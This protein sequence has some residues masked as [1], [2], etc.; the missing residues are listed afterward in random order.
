MDDGSTAYRWDA[1]WQ[2]GKLAN[3]AGTAGGS[4]PGGRDN[5]A[6]GLLPPGGKPPTGDSTASTPQT[7][8]LSGAVVWDLRTGRA[9]KVDS[10]R[11][12]AV[13]ISG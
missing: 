8:D 4:D 12:H 6:Y 3:P 11:V 13:R 9:D 7:V 10:G 5:W 1:H 2:G